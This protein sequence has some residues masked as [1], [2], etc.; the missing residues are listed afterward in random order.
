M[1]WNTSPIFEKEVYSA[2]AE[3]TNSDSALTKKTLISSGDVPTEGLR[4]DMISMFSTDTTARE[5][6]FYKNDGSTDY[7]IGGVTVAIGA[8]TGTVALQDAI[9]SLAP[10]VGYITLP[11]GYSLKV[12][13]Q[14]QVTSAKTVDIVAQG[15]KFTA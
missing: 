10:A 15:G 1:A 3:Y 11:T 9:Q 8:G 2:E 5:I 4:I 14:T 7:P 12:E 6:R 13:N